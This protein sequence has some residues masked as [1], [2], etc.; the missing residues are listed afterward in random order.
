MLKKIVVSL[1]AVMLMVVFF[2]LPTVAGDPGDVIDP[3]DENDGESDPV[4]CSGVAGDVNNNG[5]VTIGDI[6]YLLYYLDKGGPAPPCMDQADADGSCAVAFN[7]VA[8]LVQYL[9]GSGD[10]PEF[11]SE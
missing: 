10:A 11:C 9:F 6:S 7:D 3:V 4:I 2:T 5:V 8:Y 1:F